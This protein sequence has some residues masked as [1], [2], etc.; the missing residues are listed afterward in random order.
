MLTGSLNTMCGLDLNYKVHCITQG[1]AVCFSLLTVLV[2][3]GN[4]YLGVLSP[5]NVQFD[6]VIA[7]NWMVCGIVRSNQTI[8]CCAPFTFGFAR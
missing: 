7:A 3:E 6:N 5:P 2:A 4:T 8:L 1:L